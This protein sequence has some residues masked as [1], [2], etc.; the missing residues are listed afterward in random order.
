MP[1]GDALPIMPE[2]QPRCNGGLAGRVDNKTGS[3]GFMAACSGCRI[4]VKR[5]MFRYFGWRTTLFGC[6][7]CSFEIVTKV[8]ILSCSFAAN[9][10]TLPRSINAIA[11]GPS[12]SFPSAKRG[13]GRR[14]PSTSSGH[15][16]AALSNA[17]LLRQGQLTA[18]AKHHHSRPQSRGF[19]NPKIIVVANRHH[20]RI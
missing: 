13:R 1:S 11:F 3:C 7:L 19:P 17:P 12:R 6:A 9:G 18:Q 2:F 16:A 8:G 15:G 14:N 5:G 4:M 10:F 20:V